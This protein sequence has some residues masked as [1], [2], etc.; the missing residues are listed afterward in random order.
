MEPRWYTRIHIRA[1]RTKIDRGDYRDRLPSFS[2]RRKP[3]ESSL[4][5]TLTVSCGRFFTCTRHYAIRSAMLFHASSR[6]SSKVLIPRR[7][8]FGFQ[9][10][11]ETR[12]VTVNAIGGL[13]SSDQSKPCFPYQKRDKGY[14]QPDIGI[15]YLCIS[16]GCGPNVILANLPLSKLAKSRSVHHPVFLPSLSHITE[17]PSGS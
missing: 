1:L 5:A 11:S 16:S 14:R 12:R 3:L 8:L 13:I 6:R 7:S 9:R 4:P 10:V 17:L 2:S 15:S